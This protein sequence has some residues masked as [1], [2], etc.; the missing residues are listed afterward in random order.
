MI[1]FRFCH[2]DRKSSASYTNNSSNNNNKNNSNNNEAE[3]DETRG[4]A[5]HCS[6]R[7]RFAGEA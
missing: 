4:S 2:I 7:F 3:R 1:P 5:D 6:L